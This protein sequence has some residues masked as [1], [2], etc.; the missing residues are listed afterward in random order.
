MEFR[1]HRVSLAVAV[2]DEETPVLKKI[3]MQSRVQKPLLGA[4]SGDLGGEV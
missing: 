1:D 3:R 2:V 4:A